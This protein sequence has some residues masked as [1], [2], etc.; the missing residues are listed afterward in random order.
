M[1]LKGSLQTI[2]LPEVLG[3][4]AATGKSGDI[5]IRGSHIEGRLWFSNGVISAHDVVPSSD[6]AEV[7]FQLLRNEGGEFDFSEGDGR[8]EQAYPADHVDLAIAFE[9]AHA[10]LAEWAGIVTVVPSLAHW[11]TL[12]DQ[13]PAEPIVID[14]DQWALVAAVGDGRTVGQTLDARRLG[15]FDGCKAVMALVEAGLVRVSPPQD[16]PAAPAA[17]SQATTRMEDVLALAGRGTG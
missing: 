5:H 2:T 10:L 15:E 14:R 7:L 8:S 6:P 13:P 11:L 16:R 12:I 4:L 9:R 1:S 17:T 3:L